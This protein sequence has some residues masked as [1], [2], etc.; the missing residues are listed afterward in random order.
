MVEWIK[1]P[2]QGDSFVLIY[3]AVRMREIAKCSS[4]RSELMP[5]ELVL[6]SRKGGAPSCDHEAV[7][8]SFGFTWT[9]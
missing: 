6:P 5:S 2:P 3:L 4:R 1:E 7:H 9:K 8:L